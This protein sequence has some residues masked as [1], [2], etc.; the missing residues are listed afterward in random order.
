MSLRMLEAGIQAV[1]S[2]NKTEGARLLRIALKSGELTGELSAIAYLWLAETTEDR[3]QKRQYYTQAV[4]ADPASIDAKQRLANLLAQ[5]LP[6]VSPTTTPNTMPEF[7]NAPPQ[8]TG[9]TGPLGGGQQPVANHIVSVIGGPNG[10]GTAFFVAQEGI[11]V[12]TRFVVGGLERVMLELARGQQVFAQV[13]RCFPE[14]DLAFLRAEA[15]V[16]RLLAIT[17]NPRVS[18]DAGLIVI[19][20]NGQQIRARQRP[21]KRVMAPYWFTTDVLKLP[22]AGGAAVFDEQHYLVGMMTKNYSKASAYLFG[23]HISAIRRALDMLLHEITTGERRAYCPHCGSQSRA[24]AAGYFYCEVCGGVAPQART[25]NR[26]PQGDPF[27]EISPM[28]CTNCGA[29]VGYYKG[30]CLRCGQMPT[31]QPYPR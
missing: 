18:D 8:R 23:V 10:P 6:P 14:M 17:P 19:A 12:T 25:F 3:Q 20:S 2:G 31:A 11:L 1:Q 16:D 24:T 4:D 7:Q 15:H 26:Y 21:S 9:Q 28:V 27:A 30:R 13:V 22:D 5:Q 29:Q